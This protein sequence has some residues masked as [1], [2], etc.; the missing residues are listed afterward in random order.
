MFP[1]KMLDPACLFPVTIETYNDWVSSQT[2]KYTTRQ[3]NLNN[4]IIYRN[5]SHNGNDT[6]EELGTTELNKVFLEQNEFC[7]TLDLEQ[8]YYGVK[9]TE[10]KVDGKIGYRYSLCPCN[11]TPSARIRKQIKYKVDFD[12]RMVY[13]TSPEFKEVKMEVEKKVLWIL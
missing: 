6:E 1:E 9:P 2:E 7:S 11:G 5:T 4:E 12:S 3:M 13:P 8:E 10:E